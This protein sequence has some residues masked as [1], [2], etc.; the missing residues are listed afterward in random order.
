MQRFID[1]PKFNSNPL[2]WIILINHAHL[3]NARRG[4][5]CL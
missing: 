5:S 4:C 1:H 3:N 2:G